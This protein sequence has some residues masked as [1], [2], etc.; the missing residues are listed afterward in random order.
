MLNRRALI[1]LA[2]AI[3]VTG[4]ITAATP[5]LAAGPQINATITGLALRGYDPVAYFTDGKPVLGDFTITAQ[6]EGA[7]YRF[8]SED[9]KAL[10]VKEPGKYLPQFG[11]FCAFG[12]AQGYKVDGDPNVWKIV[13]NKLYLNLAPPVA[14]RWN[15]DIGGFIKTANEKWT[16]LKD[17]APSELQ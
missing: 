9:H 1:A 4:G 7:T 15:Q 16:D 13:D 5:A 11:G 12:T 3:A 8:A 10:F 14:A 6:F 2:A 17:K